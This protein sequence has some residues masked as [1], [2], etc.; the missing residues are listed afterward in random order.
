VS[1]I[2]AAAAGAAAGARTRAKGATGSPEYQ[3]GVRKETQA[4]TLTRPSDIRRAVDLYK[5]AE[6][7]FAAAASSAADID[8][9]TRS[10]ADALRRGDVERAIADAERVIGRDPRSKAA[11]DV[12]AGVKDKAQ[13]DAMAARSEAVKQHAEGTGPFKEADSVRE[14]AEKNTDPRQTRQQFTALERSRDLYATA[15]RDATGRRAEAQ[16][17]IGLAR[18]ALER[19]DL[20]AAEKALNDAVSAQPDVDGAPALRT[21]IEAA[22]RKAAP[23]PPKP[24]PTPASPPPPVTAP[25]EPSP[26]ANAAAARERD[27]TAIGATLQ[28]Y[29]AAFSRLDADEVVRVAPY[30]AGA[31]A[32]R[33]AASFR[34]LKS[35][36]MQ[37]GSG[38]LGFSEDGNNAL[39]RGTITREVVTKTAG[40]QPRRSDRVTIA[41][42]KRDGRWVITAV[43][44]S[45]G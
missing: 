1:R 40:A 17:S 36:A 29:A 25:A 42:Q 14:L 30:L 32:Q 31:P 15:A 22:R 7:D 5:Q 16:R 11:L 28:A 12:L 41:L 43:Q 2:R 6:T 21:S 34:D 13:K 37:I 10:A 4:A 33:L 26:A 8:Q 19:G 44:N 35:Y 20:P 3:S 9:L 38:E 23:E 45:G 24:T 27:R 18:S 39:F